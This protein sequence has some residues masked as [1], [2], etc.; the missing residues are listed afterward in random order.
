MTTK[1]RADYIK[2]LLI[3]SMFLGLW[4]MTDAT[5]DARPIWTFELASGG[6]YCFRTPLTIHQSGHKD[7]EFFADYATHSFKLPIYYAC[8]FAAWNLGRAWEAEFIHLKMTVTNPPHDVQHFEISHGYNLLMLNHAWNRRLTVLRAGVGIVVSHPENTVRGKLLAGSNG[9]FNTAYHF[10]GPAIQFDLGRR[11]FLGNKFF[12]AMS[13][14][15]TA[16]YARV[17]VADGHADV[18][19]VAVHAL[20]GIGREF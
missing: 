16:A 9:L 18:P 11:C 17:P 1:K 19:N 7:I 14:K 20:I 3:K 12:I 8:R 13:G 4:L 15:I 2:K 10:S 5:I 6:A